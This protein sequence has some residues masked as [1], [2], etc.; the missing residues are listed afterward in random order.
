MRQLPDL[1]CTAAAGAAAAVSCVVLQVLCSAR[2][3]CILTA[4]LQHFIAFGAG[5]EGVAAAA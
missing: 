1:E 4:A 2:R 5:V 3:V